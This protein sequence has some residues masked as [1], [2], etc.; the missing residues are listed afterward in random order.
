ML[1]PD[2]NKDTVFAP[3]ERLWYLVSR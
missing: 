1:L 2:E 3:V